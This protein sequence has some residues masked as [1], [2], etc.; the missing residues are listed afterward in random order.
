MGELPSCY[1][2]PAL[3]HRVYYNLLSNAL[4]FSRSRSRTVIGIG[5]LQKDGK[6][7][8]F[9][10]DNGIGFDMKYV[11]K[12]FKVFERLHDSSRYEGTGV[13]LAIVQ[14]IVARHGGSVWAE[15]E[16]DKGATFYFTLGEGPGALPGH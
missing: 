11:D 4:K 12:I 6:T 8:Y 1:A 9:V 7:V 10:Q 14:R 15:S 2:D 5:T 3:L 16:A 13:G